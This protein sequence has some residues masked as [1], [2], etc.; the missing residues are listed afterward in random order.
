MCTS[1]RCIPH[2]LSLNTLLHTRINLRC[3][4]DFIM[5]LNG[6]AEKHILRYGYGMKLEQSRLFPLPIYETTLI[7]SI[8]GRD[9]T[10][11]TLYAGVNK[12]HVA[13]LKSFSL[14]KMDTAIQENTSDRRRFGEGS[15]EDW[16]AKNRTPFSLIHTKTNKLA[17]LIWFG[18]K[19]LG[20]KSMK[21]LT[22]VEQRKV[23]ATDS[24]NG[25]TIA[26]RAYQP[27]RGVGIMKKA[28]NAAT[29]A[30]LKVFPDALIWTVVD[31]ANEASIGLSKALGYEVQGESEEGFVVMVRK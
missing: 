20:M 6:V 19:P 7:G 21:H 13:Q 10:T 26:Y 2:N 8:E 4:S 16:Y 27:Y 3:I 17:A 30:Y 28:V 5:S 15:Y 11:F 31:E 24:G 12:E 29:E 1:K 18:P 9:D 22:D 25:H 14:D 23:S